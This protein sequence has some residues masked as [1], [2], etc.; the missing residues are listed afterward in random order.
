MVNYKESEK[1]ILNFLLVTIVTTHLPP[2]NA[3]NVEMSWGGPW[4]W[5]NMH[6][7]T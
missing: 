4:K 7:N 2:Y 5:T 3:K 1:E 6:K